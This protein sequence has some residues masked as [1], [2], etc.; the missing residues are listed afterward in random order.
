MTVKLVD[1]ARAIVSMR[2]SDFDAY[3]A[4]GEIIDNSIQAKAEMIKMRMD[5]GGGNKQIVRSVAFGDDG[6]GMN[7]EVLHQC[8]QLGYSSRY[9]DRSGIGRFGVGATLAAIK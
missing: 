8:M 5:H 2:E 1:D 6:H 7:K 4:M 3:S 9:N